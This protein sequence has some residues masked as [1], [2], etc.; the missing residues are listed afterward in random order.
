MHFT[1]RFFFNRIIFPNFYLLG[2]PLFDV[3]QA[4]HI[5]TTYLL[6]KLLFFSENEYEC[7][8]CLTSLKETKDYGAV[9]KLECG[10]EYH[11]NCIGKWFEQ[12]RDCPQCRNYV[13]PK[14]EYPALG[15]HRNIRH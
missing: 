12:K 1:L 3:S 14:E 8:I 11:I 7:S 10:H 6:H 4:C 9:K 2:W 5:G 13:V 15:L